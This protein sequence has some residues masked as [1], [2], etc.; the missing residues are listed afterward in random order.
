MTKLSIDNIVIRETATSYRGKPLVVELHPGYLMIHEKG[1]HQG[2]M[3]DY[4]AAYEVAQKIRARDERN[5]Q[6]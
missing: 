1:A 6:H 5:S 3:L 4:A 2:Y